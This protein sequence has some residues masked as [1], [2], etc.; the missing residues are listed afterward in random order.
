MDRV[1]LQLLIQ[2]IYSEVGDRLCGEDAT[3]Y[4]DGQDITKCFDTIADQYGEGWALGDIAEKLYRF[5]TRGNP[6]DLMK[7][8]GRIVLLIAWMEGKHVRIDE[9]SE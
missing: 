7:A 3:K 1:S 5:K 8:I 4:A 9:K 6:D 2:Q